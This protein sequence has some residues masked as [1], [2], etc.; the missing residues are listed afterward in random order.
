MS[1]RTP[2]KLQ[3]LQA[4]LSHKAKQEP[5]S[6]F[7]FLY[8]KVWRADILAHA[9]ALNRENSGAAGV[10][11]Q[12]VADIEDYGVERWLAELQEEVGTER[13]QPQP[14]RRVLIPKESGVGDRPLGI[15]MVLSYCTS[16]QAA[17]GLLLSLSRQRRLVAF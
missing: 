9:Y 11:G 6:R 12:T 8:D 14:V 3:S 17:S 10:D 4:A 16:I 5:S 1:L 15:P 7:H 13:Y 2:D